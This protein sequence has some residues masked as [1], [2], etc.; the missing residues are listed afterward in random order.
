[1]QGCFRF[2]R[3]LLVRLSENVKGCAGISLLHN[4]SRGGQKLKEHD[5]QDSRQIK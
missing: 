2:V 1:V 5:E 3:A 4:S